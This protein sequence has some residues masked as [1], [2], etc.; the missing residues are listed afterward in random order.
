MQNG[1]IKLHNKFLKWEWYQK[2]E[3]VH[4]FIH[5]LLSAN[6]KEN[7]WQGVKIKP[8]QLVIGRKK[9]AET[10]GISQQT[11]RTCITR[12]KSTNEITTKSTNKYTVITILNW[13]KYQGGKINQPTDKPL[14]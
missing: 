8:G 13:S 14:F 9:L 11:L 5:F 6:Y 1:W 12:L 2:P 7:S 10:L 4:L 3:M